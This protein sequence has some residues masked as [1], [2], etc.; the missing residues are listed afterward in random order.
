MTGPPECKDVS[1]GKSITSCFKKDR[2]PLLLSLPTGLSRCPPGAR[3]GWHAAG[4]LRSAGK[5]RASRPR[6]RAGGAEPCPGGGRSGGAVPVPVLPPHSPPN[7][8]AALRME[9]CRRVRRSGTAGSGC[10]LPAAAAPAVPLSYGDGVSPPQS[11][12]TPPPAGHLKSVT[13]PQY[14]AGAPPVQLPPPKASPCSRLH[15]KATRQ[16]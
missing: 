3:W 6:P 9:R 2:N 12:G 14:I 13:V 7:L 1:P 5:L 16:V 8:R 4:R 10:H 11:L 15:K